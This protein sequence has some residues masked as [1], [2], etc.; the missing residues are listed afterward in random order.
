VT[1][2]I[3]YARE[4]T[5]PQLTDRKQAHLLSAGVPRNDP[6]VDQGVSGARP[7]RPQF[8]RVHTTLEP[9]DV[10]VITTLDRFR[11]STQSKL[12]FSQGLRDCGAGPRVLHL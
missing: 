7:S 1:K 5:R 8:D 4:S 11:R 3:G 2:L 6:Y 12:D 10:F 9:G